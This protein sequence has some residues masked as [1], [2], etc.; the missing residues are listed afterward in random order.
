MRPP[1]RSVPTVVGAAL[2]VGCALASCALVAGCA[3]AG[4][5]SS[6]GTGSTI[7]IG[8]LRPSTGP[9]TANG[10]DMQNGWDLFWAEHGA[11][12]AGKKVET[13]AEDTAGNPSVA[14][15][16]ANQLT[17]SQHVNMI[18]GPLSASEGL[19]VADAM[20][21]KGVIT[22]MPIVSADDLTQRKR[23]KGIVRLAGWT[24]SQTTHPFGEYAY[25]QGYRRI[26]TI[27]YDFAFGY[28]GVGGFVNTF[29][30]RGGTIVNQLWAPLGTQDYGTYVTQIKNAHPD[31]VFAFLSGADAVRL[32]Q[33]YRDFGLLGKVP[34]L[35]GETLTDQSVLQD[36]GD[37]A[38]G[39]VTSGH[40]AEG[41]DDATTRGFVDRYT[42]RY[43]RY[44]S[45]YSADAYTAARGI[46]DAIEA[47]HGDLSSNDNVIKAL[48]AVSLA[49]TPMGPE[50][51]D[52][53]G[54]PVFNVYIRT[55]QKGPHGP[56]NVPVKTY[57]KVSQFW[58]YDPQQFLSHPVYSKTYQGNGVWPNPTS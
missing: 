4:D 16:K 55:V 31:A 20:S 29:T 34:L 15:N 5:K 44:P 51:L 28:E 12:V 54:N 21:R 13:I 6:G 43:H 32:F 38:V 9:L 57:P 37:T 1:S 3:P 24:S 14:L 2:V 18:V 42:A 49:Q 53:Y 52:G 47:L 36:L 41:R 39:L 19:A 33:A 46:A 30:D 25:Q 22:V 8:L 50:S 27:G 45:Y 7:R 17:D 23:L 40:F 35:G 48:D 58:Q 56:W 11:T 10:A 26:V